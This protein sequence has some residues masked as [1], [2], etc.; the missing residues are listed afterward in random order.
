MI[1]D[2]LVG[3]ADIGK[4]SITGSNVMSMKLF[5]ITPTCYVTHALYT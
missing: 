3:A 4:M 5:P 2:V 1:A